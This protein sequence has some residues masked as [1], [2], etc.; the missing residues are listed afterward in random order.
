MKRWVNR[1]NREEEVP[2][3][4]KFLEEVVEVCERHK[5]TLSHEDLNG[6]FQVEEMDEANME[7]L[8][9]AEDNRR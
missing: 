5:L 1:N 4:D 3:I 7:W 8:R 2:E 9:N 6:A